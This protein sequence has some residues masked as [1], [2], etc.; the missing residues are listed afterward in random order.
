MP[1]P[2]ASPDAA[3]API[4]IRDAV[5]AWAG[6]WLL[7]SVLSAAVAQSSGHTTLAETPAGWVL[8]A[9]LAL[10]APMVGA[11]WYVGSRHGTGSLV[12]D[13]AYRFRPLDLVGVP[14]GVVTQL[15]VLPLVY[16]PLGHAW[17]DTFGRSHL[18]KPA[19]D[20]WNTGH[21]IGVLAIV[22]VA[23]IGAPLVEEL[24][25]RG[26]LQ[27]AFVRCTD[28]VTGLLL[29]AVW[30]AAIHFQPAQMPGLF[31]IGL[32]L[33]IAA[34]RTGRLGMAVLIHLAFNATGLVLV[35]R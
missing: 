6:S 7:G 24:M 18:E 22:F 10:W 9:Q 26:L 21:G 30:F 3:A 11:A 14:I 28:R 29:V 33:G 31:V 35:A 17:P 4:P 13:Y 19:R 20:L 8:L 16:W 2:S 1:R 23:V 25:Y 15:A 34:V 12:R 27:G 5:V 32:V